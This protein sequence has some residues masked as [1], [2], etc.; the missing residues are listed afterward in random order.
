MTE[1]VAVV[2]LPKPKPG[3]TFLDYYERVGDVATAEEV[4]SRYASYWGVVKSP[5]WTF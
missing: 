3:E 4:L 5:W 2:S 1:E